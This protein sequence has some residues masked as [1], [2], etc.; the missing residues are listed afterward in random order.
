[1]EK[2]GLARDADADFE[3]PE[4]AAPVARCVRTC[5]TRS[6]VTSTVLQQ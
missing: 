3:H 4:R 1:M 2:I 5:S 6:R